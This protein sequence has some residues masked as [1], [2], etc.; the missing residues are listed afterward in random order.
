MKTNRIFLLK[1]ISQIRNVLFHKKKNHDSSKEC[2]K[3]LHELRKC[4]LHGEFKNEKAES[5]TKID[6]VK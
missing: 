6:F 3:T 5:K 4:Y 2:E 1:V